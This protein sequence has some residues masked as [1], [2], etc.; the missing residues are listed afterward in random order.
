MKEKWKIFLIFY[1]LSVIPLV[2]YVAFM[3]RGSE[4]LVATVLALIITWPAVVAG[5]V[6]FGWRKQ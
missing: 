5:I 3:L 2:A 1:A 6:F 4:N